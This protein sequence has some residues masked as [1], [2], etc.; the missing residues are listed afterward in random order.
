MFQVCLQAGGVIGLSIQAGLFTVRPGN[1]A[2]FYN[3]QLSLWFM[4]GWATLNALLALI[5]F[6]DQAVVN[7]LPPS[8]GEMIA[9]GTVHDGTGPIISG[10]QS[11]S[12]GDGPEAKNER[13]AE[14]TMPPL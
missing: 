13:A 1:V 11:E 7:A 3:V 5:F 14:S 4:A 12:G 2:D 6:R 9:A 10:S 8:T